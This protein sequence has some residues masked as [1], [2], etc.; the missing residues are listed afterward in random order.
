MMSI[1]PRALQAIGFAAAFALGTLASAPAF[2]REKAA[3]TA[4][5]P[6]AQHVM[7]V[8]DPMPEATI[9]PVLLRIGP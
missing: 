4:C 2:A 7:T 9:D 1:N 6:S 5:T 8:P 3:Q